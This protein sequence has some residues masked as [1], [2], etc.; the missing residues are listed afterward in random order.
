MNHYDQ[1][2]GLLNLVRDLNT[3]QRVD[4]TL[5]RMELRDFLERRGEIGKLAMHVLVTHQT[6][7]AEEKATTANQAQ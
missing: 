5:S 6:I 4:Y 2:Q 1:L 3:E 7:Q